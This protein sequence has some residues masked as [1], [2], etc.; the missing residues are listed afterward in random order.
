[1]NFVRQK[2]VDVVIP[3]F[4]KRIETNKEQKVTKY[5][6][7]F[8][9]IYEVLSWED[10]RYSLIVF[11]VF[12]YLF[13]LMVQWQIKIVGLIF[14]ILLILFLFDT[15]FPH[16]RQ[17]EQPIKSADMVNNTYIVIMDIFYGMKAFRNENSLTFCV[18]MSI[19]FLIIN[20]I[21][22][23]VSGY[24]ICYLLLLLSFFIPLGIKLLPEEVTSKIVNGIKY[25]FNVKGT[26]AEEELVP[27][28]CDK[29]FNNRDAD[30]D[31]LCTDRTADSVSNSLI[32]GISTMPSFLDMAEGDRDIEEEDLI[33][34][35]TPSDISSDSD[36]DHKEM[37]IDSSHF[38][39]DSSSEE[40]RFLDNTA[41][42]PAD[43]TDD[44]GNTSRFASVRSNIGQLVSNVWSY[45]GSS[46]KPEIKRQNSSSSSSE[47]E[48]VS[49]SDVKE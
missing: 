4:S 26:L 15:F 2:F 20:I 40:E 3:Y 9:K 38:N 6:Q 27:F 37:S 49:S 8:E 28:I 12:N 11:V 7:Y 22:R 19:V 42:F 18:G 1:M 46:T 14:F 24:L 5:G 36:L 34:P 41:V 13:W 29:D 35:L 45:A 23:S 10:T 25:T 21:A 33:P 30:L 16:S 17:I 47:F 32:S 44:S 43:F 39:G 31:S 48:F